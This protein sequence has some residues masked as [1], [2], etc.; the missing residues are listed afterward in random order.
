[1]GGITLSMDA[2][3]KYQNMRHGAHM[4]IL[5]GWK[6]FSIYVCCFA[7]LTCG[8]ALTSSLS[9]GTAGGPPGAVEAADAPAEAVVNA[10]DGALTAAAAGA[11]ACEVGCMMV[12][13][14]TFSCTRLR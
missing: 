11:A 1:M 10:G 13:F 4:P 5:T 7:P 3:N 14:D 8:A 12:G 6:H 9:P 2:N